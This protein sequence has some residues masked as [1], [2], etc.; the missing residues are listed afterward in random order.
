MVYQRTVSTRDVAEA[1]HL[2]PATVQ[3][4]A[5]NGRIPFDNTPGGHHRYN[6]EEVRAVL[7]SAATPGRG[8]PG[9]QRARKWLADATDLESWAERRVAQDEFPDLVRWLIA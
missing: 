2:R 6:I 7:E 3:L 8:A 4:Y 9:G 5:R 1:L